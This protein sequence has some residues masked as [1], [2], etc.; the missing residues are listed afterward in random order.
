MTL[1]AAVDADRVEAKYKN[2]VLELRL[3]KTEQAKRKKIAVT[4]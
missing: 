1:P 4:G 2:G 3:P